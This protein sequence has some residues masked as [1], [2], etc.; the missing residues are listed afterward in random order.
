MEKENVKIANKVSVT[1]LII[2]VV[3][4]VFK[5]FAGIF[6]SSAAMVSDAVHTMS[7]VLSTV[8]VIIGV[9]MA[10]QKSDKAHQYGHERFECVASIILAALLA[11]TGAG[12]G[13]SAV[14][15][16][17]NGGYKT[18]EPGVLALI[19]AFVSI[20]TKEWMY[21]FTRA[22]AKKTSSGALMADAWHH[23]SDAM[24]SVG[25]LIGI[26]GARMGFPVLDSV[27]GLVICVFII[28]TSFDI[29][30]DAINK[31]VD[32]ACDEGTL[33]RLR[34]VVSEQEGVIEVDEIRTRIFGS[35]MFVDIE[36]A[37]DG[38]I[39]LER[40]HVIAD[41]VHDSVEMG[42]PSVKHC[43]VHV[44]PYKKDTENGDKES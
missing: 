2:N 14:T 10:G 12:I 11:L 41:S 19:A 24:S 26:L 28:K 44:N 21:W 17:I 4:S 30:M 6:A 43:M 16:I 15:N 35:K 8:I 42:F 37:A 7:D 36:I 31:M 33:T 3:L 5:L 38:D 18:M 39:T 29:F 25:A 32:K 9:N 20:G 27:A 23:R 1:T 22:A 13:E 34:G 40:A